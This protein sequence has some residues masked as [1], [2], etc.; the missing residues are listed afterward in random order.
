MTSNSSPR[1]KSYTPPKGQQTP[2]QAEL[3]RRE[4]ERA[5]RQANLQWTAVIIV[6]LVLLG[7]VFVFGSGTGGNLDHVPVGGH[8]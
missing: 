2:S 6:G 8:N 4:R 7:L 3:D 5:A 1:P